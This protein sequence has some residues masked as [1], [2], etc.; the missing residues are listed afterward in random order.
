MEWKDFGSIGLTRLNNPINGSNTTVFWY[1][2]YR[3]NGYYSLANNLTV[4]SIC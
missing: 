2:L 4:T 3:S 1:E